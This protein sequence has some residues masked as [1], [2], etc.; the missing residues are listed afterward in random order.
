LSIVML[1]FSKTA[2]QVLT[3]SDRQP[4][5]VFGNR[6]AVLSGRRSAHMPTQQAC[7]LPTE[8]NSLEDSMPT[9]SAPAS[10]A[11]EMGLR[12]ERTIHPSVLDVALAVVVVISGAAW[13]CVSL[14][15]VAPDL[16]GALASPSGRLLAGVAGLASFAAVF[17]A[18]PVWRRPRPGNERSLL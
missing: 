15:G 3:D 17:R 18:F 6:Y 2:L 7:L 11:E 4:A 5:L 8:V 10:L 14:V 16:I 1:F 13:L 12:L 9:R